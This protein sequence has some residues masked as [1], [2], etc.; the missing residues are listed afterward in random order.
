MGLDAAAALYPDELAAWSAFNASG[1]QPAGVDRPLHE[2]LDEI[3]EEH[4]DRL[5]VQ[6]PDGRLSYAELRTRAAVCAARLR[7]RGCGPGARVGVLVDRSIALY[8]LLYACARSG[9]TYVPIDPALQGGDGIVAQLATRAQ[10][11]V[12]VA[13]GELT[14]PN[15]G[16]CPLVS[17]DELTTPALTGTAGDSWP[18]TDADAGAP[19]YVIHTSGTTGV[20][21]GVVIARSSMINLATWYRQRH[22]VEPG[23]RLSQ[24]APLTFDPS[25]Q[26][27]FTAWLSGAS[28]QVA[29][30]GAR[31]DPAEFLSWLRAS[32]ISHLDMATA[33]WAS[34]CDA[35]PER[36]DNLPDLR[37]SIV[38]GESMYWPQAQRWFSRTGPRS[39]LDNI[40]GPTEATI[41]A[42]E[43][44]VLRGAAAL[45]GP[46]DEQRVPIGSP[47]PGYR[48]YLLDQADELCPPSITGEIV[49]AGDGVALGYL[50]APELTSQRFVEIGI[51]GRVERCYRTGD[52]AELAEHQQGRWLLSFRGRS[53]RQVKLSGHRLELD[54]V[55]RLA[56][57]LP[58][59][60]Q[61]AVLALGDP[62]DRLAV[63]FVGSSSAAQVRERLVQ[64]LP[65]FVRFD[66]VTSL[67]Q[68]PTTEAGKLDR[69]RLLRERAGTS[70]GTGS[71]ETGNFGDG[72][73]EAGGFGDDRPD[74]DGA[75][76]EMISRAWCQELDLPRVPAGASFFELGGSSLAAFRVVA[77]LRKQGVR[78]HG[79]DYLQ[80]PTLERCLALARAR[81]GAATD[82]RD[83]LAY[84]RVINGSDPARLAGELAQLWRLRPARTEEVPP[85][86]PLAA[87]WLRRPAATTEVACIEFELPA[88][89]ESDRLVRAAGAVLA[90][91]SA[92]RTCLPQAGAD[93]AL[94]T[95]PAPSI[96]VIERA[97]F[98][99]DV[100]TQVRELAAS[101]AARWDGPARAVVVTDPAGGQPSRLLIL[102]SHA[103]VHAG[104]IDAVEAELVQAID[105]A[106]LPGPSDSHGLRAWWR[107]ADRDA[108]AA[109]EPILQQWRAFLHADTELHRAL[110]RI[111][112]G[113]GD[114]VTLAEWELRPADTDLEAGWV[115]LLAALAEALAEQTGLD[116][117]PISLI[118]APRPTAARVV[119]P[120]M[121]NLL[122]AVPLLLPSHDRLDP[123]FCADLLATSLGRCPHWV[124]AALSQAAAVI[125][126]WPPGRS[127]LFGT[128]RL[129]RSTAELPAGAPGQPRRQPPS[130]VSGR[131][132]WIELTQ[133][134]ADN[135]ISIT[136]AN[137]ARPVTDALRDA[138]AVRLAATVASPVP[139]PPGS[140]CT[141]SAAPA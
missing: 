109:S 112:D 127:A 48:V 105:G 128:V 70:A 80:D 68:L 106:P 102:A 9:W 71:F 107:E 117:L 89:L 5:A 27:I 45:T 10:L 129:Q 90:A 135:R 54:A 139:V 100:I 3:A 99:E 29:P 114:P 125:D 1:W 62:A 66:S 21:K 138:L 13:S 101:D 76:R 18:V 122:D 56:A 8:P 55:E 91:H 75:L 124:A 28:V 87:V 63:W 31:L 121:V 7:E 137:L 73:F 32:R 119:V 44:E 98:D 52:L 111:S 126:D 134:C 118:A 78:C 93:T 33:H 12:I 40:Y 41:N 95:A 14:S 15:F 16:S 96:P 39:R 36:P 59:V 72:S 120:P 4:P 136:A 24:N 58:E 108:R 26:Q 34:L 25:A 69:A 110:G 92:L 6:A 30:A 116:Q 60:S 141:T 115:T 11:A 43:F 65:A 103:L 83:P 23:D 81:E 49:I 47:L 88:D 123:A 132:H 86:G 131:D 104:V 61:V 38:A 37:W 77:E 79:A 82:G 140:I 2:L 42:T 50:N 85:L 97:G 51:N 20:P 46:A 67:T 133:H 57:G 74:A 94:V 22:H 130:R 53:D 64:N 113:S 19:L 17:V 35:L 84:G